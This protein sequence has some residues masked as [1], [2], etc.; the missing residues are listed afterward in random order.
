M[1]SL[2]IPSASIQSHSI[3]AFPKTPARVCID[4]L[5][6]RVDNL[7]VM[8]RSIPAGPIERRSREP[9]SGAGSPG[10]QFVVCH[11]ES[12]CLALS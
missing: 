4:F 1:D 3:E 7:G 9:Y 8:S 10:T 2:V 5:I 6:Q 12:N 11:Q